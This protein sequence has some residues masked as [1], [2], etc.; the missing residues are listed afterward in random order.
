MSGFLFDWPYAGV[1]LAAL[2]LGW[3]ALERRKEGAPPRWQDP[4]WVL[5]LLWPMY[6]L[7]QFE[8]H[9]V[10]LQGRH[11]SFLEGLCKTLGYSVQAGCPADPPF[12]F[13][14]NGVGCQLAFAMSWIFRRR[15][16]LVAACAWG[17]ALVNAVT[18]IGAGLAHRAYN[19]GLL[20]SL[21]LFLPLCALML[22]TAIRSGAIE[23]RDVLRIIATGAA[24]HAV[25]LVSL[26][27]RANGTLS[28]GAILLINTANGLWPLVFGLVGVKRATPSS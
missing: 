6:L 26:V 15:N 7:H 22:R 16:P 9:G 13:A 25:L 17:I 8:E 24:A 18:H 19:P 23:R 21:I 4:A 5:P 28:H 12:I 10:D 11:Y 3:L 20:S 2:L 14:V 1:G 27:L